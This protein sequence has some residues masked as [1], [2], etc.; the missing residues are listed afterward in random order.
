VAT[1][2][3]GAHALHRAGR[4]GDQARDAG[5]ELH[6]DATA[7]HLGRELAADHRQDR[8]AFF[9]GPDVPG[10]VVGLATDGIA[11]LRH[12]RQRLQARV[13]QPVDRGRRLVDGQARDVA[14]GEAVGQPHH[15]L[16]V[17]VRR[18]LD[19]LGELGL[20]AR[21]TDL[22]VGEMQR[23]ADVLGRVDQQHLRAAARG[24][25][26]RRQPGRAGTDDH[27]VVAGGGHRGRTAGQAGK[28][29]DRSGRGGGLDEG[30]AF[31]AAESM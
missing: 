23:A 18:V 14:V 28:R 7:R 21:G 11:G 30:S 29:G 22:A 26:R 5:A 12:V 3:G 9:L 31:H 2:G 13:D 16:E 20:R 19:A 8:A 24:E 15:L 1:V 6:R 27:E 4:V 10:N 17:L 25:D